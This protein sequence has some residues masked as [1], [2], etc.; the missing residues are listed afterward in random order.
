[1]TQVVNIYIQLE[2]NG[3]FAHEEHELTLS[4]GETFIGVAMVLGSEQ[5]TG[6][7]QHLKPIDDESNR[8]LQ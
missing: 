2:N 3:Q 8:L 5:T 7:D 4:E 6:T 1:M